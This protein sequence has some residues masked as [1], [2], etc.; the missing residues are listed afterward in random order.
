MNFHT[1]LEERCGFKFPEFSKEYRFPQLITNAFHDT[2]S[3]K[4][5]IEFRC[6]I[7]QPNFFSTPEFLF[8]TNFFSTPEFLFNTGISN[9]DGRNIHP[10][11]RPNRRGFPKNN[12]SYYFCSEW[13]DCDLPPPNVGT[14]RKSHTNLTISTTKT[15]NKTEDDHH[16][17]STDPYNFYNNH[18]WVQN[19]TSY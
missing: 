8:N 5:L 11:F 15:K 2:F 18:N 3:K 12:S 10:P 7:K 17:Q 13:Y 4:E 9:A 19:T 16:H 1:R 6:W 14:L